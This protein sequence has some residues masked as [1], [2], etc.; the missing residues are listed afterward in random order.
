LENRVRSNL[1]DL[2]KMSWERERTPCF[3]GGISWLKP[4]VQQ[5]L[6]TPKSNNTRLITSSYLYTMDNPGIRRD[7]FRMSSSN[8]GYLT[9]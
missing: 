4:G 8:Y 5:V 1:T 9:A 6:V 2:T 7:F 3:S